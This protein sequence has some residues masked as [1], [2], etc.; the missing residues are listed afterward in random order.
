MNP[1]TVLRTAE[2][3]IDIDALMQRCLS[4]PELVHR[5]LS[6]FE[7]AIDQSS[8]ECELALSRQD[9]FALAKV[10]H[11]MRG[12]ALSVSA[13][14]LVGILESLEHLIDTQ[15]LVAPSDLWESFWDECKAVS[16][17]LK[18]RPRD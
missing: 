18:K 8:T 6:R 15:G 1:I 10:L 9:S 13:N 17:W 12:S 14:R 11:R 7:R 4:K 3:P 5:V 2:S 16:D